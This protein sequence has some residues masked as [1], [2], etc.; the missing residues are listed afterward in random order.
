[1]CRQRGWIGL[2]ATAV[3]AMATGDV[4]ARTQALV[5]TRGCDRLSRI[6][7]DAVVAALRPGSHHRANEEVVDEPLIVS[8]DRT[9][10]TVS[11][12][13]VDGMRWAGADI[14]WRWPGGGP[15]DVCLSGF[16]DQCYPDRG[17]WGLGDPVMGATAAPV[18]EAV[19]ET[20][21]RAMPL[22]VASDQSVF[23]AGPMRQALATALERSAR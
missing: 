5:E 17:A 9:T 21:S 22:G 2:A 12:A 18:W 15:G 23:A 3:L 10:A 4:T 11:A 1:M 6:V 19:L 16:L 13:F 14:G 7:T 20:V 8:C